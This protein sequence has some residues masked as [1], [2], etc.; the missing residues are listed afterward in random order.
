ME[1]GVTETTFVDREQELAELEGFL[2]RA[3]EGNGQ[4]CFVVGQ[5]GSGKTA[6]VHHFVE[7]AF[8]ADPD[9]VLA[10]GTCNAQTGVGDP[11]LPFRE[12][13]AMLTGDSETR[14]PATAAPVENTRRLRTVLVRSVQILVEVTPELVG[15]F[16][17][18]AKLLGHFGKAIANKTGWT[19]RLEALTQKKPPTVAPGQTP[20]EQNRLIEQYTNFIQH[21]ANQTPLILFLDDLQWSDAASLSLLFHL[22]RHI[23]KSRIL[24]LGAYRANDVAVGRDGARH[25]LEAVVNELTRYYGDVTV[26]LDAIPE[27]ANRRFVDALVDTQPNRLDESFRQAL[28]DRTGGHAL[29]TVELIRA[30]QERGGL[31]RDGE[32]RWV[33]A[34]DLDWEAFPARIEGVIEERV[35]RLTDDQ[36]ATLNV[37]S[38]EGETFTGEVVARVREM[39]ER[40]AIR[41][42]SAELQR[43][44]QLV[45]NRG[46]LRVGRIQVSR[47]RFTHN[48]FQDYLYQALDPAERSYYHQDVGR[49]LEG[50][51][52]GET[53]EVA[54]ELAR[55]FEGAHE[56]GKAALYRLQAGHRSRRMSAHEE[57]VAHLTRGLELVAQLP[58]G[59]EQ[60]QLELELQITL[61]TVLIAMFGY[62]SPRVDHVFARARELCRR[63]GDP[64]QLIPALLGQALFSLMRGDMETAQ[65]EGEHSLT[66]AQETGHDG[67]RIASHFLLGVAA[68]YVADYASARRNLEEAIGLYDPDQHAGL[69]Y[70]QG[71]DPAVGSLS[72]LARTLWLQGYPEQAFIRQNEAIALADR[73]DHPYSRTVALLHAATL[74]YFRQ[75][76]SECQLLAEKAHVVADQR[77]FSLWRANAAVLRGAALA[78]QGRTDEG[79]AQL[80]QGLFLWEATGAGLVAFGRAC[81]AEACLL[82]GRRDEGLRMIDESLYR[83]E[84]SWWLPEQYRLR[85]ELLQLWPGNEAEAEE[86]LRTA[87]T[88]AREHES[89]SLELRVA[90][91]LARLLQSQKQVEEAQALLVGP[92]NWFREGLATVE[93]EQAR[94]LMAG[95]AN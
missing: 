34:G 19:D 86:Q 32:E 87:L 6:L 65:Q 41:Q 15:V 20:N 64:P 47:Y 14:R 49:A 13:L 82:G 81:L 35:A 66:L 67:F 72:F 46:M 40:D 74:A 9:L 79:I 7:Q 55:H 59:A 21:F 56:I 69:A 26:D 70:E 29:F 12:A 17:P 51:F 75:E 94:E 73:L 63:L 71:Q 53:E 3:L 24:V 58:P 95:T 42:L 2:K 83:P 85:A 25:P 88:L 57:A 18:G 4:V 92:Y 52:G 39:K 80:S 68:M 89:R 76:W 27:G 45:Y 10:V 33:V 50:L 8:A 48:V 91:S 54:A 60:I 36:R 77:N 37:A 62:G 22:G 44:H 78:H 5:A 93:L 90:T 16:V 28:F 30:L 31:V 43:Q 1:R 84:E 38:V 61:G 11:Y 23:S